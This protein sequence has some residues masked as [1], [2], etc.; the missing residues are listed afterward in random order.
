MAIEVRYQPNLSVYARA[1]ADAAAKMEGDRRAMA[2]ANV[3]L[4]A[5]GSQ[6]V[7]GGNTTQIGGVSG[8]G[9]ITNYAALAQKRAQE[10]ANSSNFFQRAGMGGYDMYGGYPVGTYAQPTAQPQ[11]PQQPSMPTQQYI[12][13]QGATKTGSPTWL[14]TLD[15]YWLR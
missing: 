5:A 12:V 9:D 13:N 3:R 7:L 6:T 1:L 8:G 2:A 15:N 14:Q 4:A 10:E 11:M